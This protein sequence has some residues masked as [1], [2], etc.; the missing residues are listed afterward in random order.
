M[1]P[2]LGSLNVSIL[3]PGINCRLQ[4]LCLTWQANCSL[5]ADIN[6]F[7][8]RKN[9]LG[10]LPG[11]AWTKPLKQRKPERSLPAASRPR[12]REAAG[13]GSSPGL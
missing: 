13:L 7:P 1:V 6:S 4:L 3:L 5:D 2:S 9:K 11:L 12:A 8:K 10:F